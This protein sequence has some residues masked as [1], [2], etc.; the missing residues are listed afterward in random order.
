MRGDAQKTPKPKLRVAVSRL[1]RFS[2]PHRGSRIN[3]LLTKFLWFALDAENQCPHF[4]N[5]AESF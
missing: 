4:F 1:R 5:D 2:G 3:R